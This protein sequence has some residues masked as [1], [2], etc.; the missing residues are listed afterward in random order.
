MNQI[1]KMFVVA[2]FGLFVL[3]STVQAAAKDYG[4]GNA[5][6]NSTATFSVDFSSD[7]K[8][9]K[10]S[11]SKTISHYIVTLCSGPLPKVENI[12][13]S[14]VNVGPYV[15]PIVSVLVKA[16]TSSQTFYTKANCSGELTPTPTPPPGPDPTPTPHPASTCK[17]APS[18]SS[19]WPASSRHFVHIHSKSFG[20][21]KRFRQN[22]CHRHY[23]FDN[24]QR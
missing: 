18:D 3:T 12:K 9:A 20:L 16:G 24:S 14:T 17:T 2:L 23:R 11:S 13:T 10:V 21:V 19:D 4:N 6:P 5:N 7:L 22:H 15:S 1:S 8:S